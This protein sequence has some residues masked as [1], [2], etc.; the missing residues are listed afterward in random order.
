MLLLSSVMFATKVQGFAKVGKL[1][2]VACLATKDSV[3]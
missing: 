1:Y 3:S 2:S